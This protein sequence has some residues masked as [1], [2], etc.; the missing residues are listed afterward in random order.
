MYMDIA[1]PD[2]CFELVP[3]LKQ[4]D[5]YELPTINKEPLLSLLYPFRIQRKNIITFSL[6]NNKD[7]VIAMWGVCPTKENER[8]GVIWY[9]SSE[10][11]MQSFVKFCKGNIPF[12]RYVEE[13]YDF[14]FNICT[15][16]QK[17]TIKWLKFL[18]FTFKNTP[19]LVK[20]Q[21]ML[22]FYKKPN[23]KVFRGVKPILK[24]LGP[25]YWATQKDKNG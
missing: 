19:V 16:E 15:P 4:T 6:F 2:D 20:G 12:V 3:K 23:I 13:H 9:L 8:I 18:G 5:R 17:K 22:Y 14:L 10:E 11:P 1:I 21:K 24:H 7:E 25:R